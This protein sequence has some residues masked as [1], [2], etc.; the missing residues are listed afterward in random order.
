VALNLSTQNGGWRCPNDNDHRS[1]NTQ[2]AGASDTTHSLFPA[3]AH[4]T[5]EVSGQM[6]VVED[7]PSLYAVG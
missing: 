6:A 7:G 4:A 3:V 5:L 1:A 2:A